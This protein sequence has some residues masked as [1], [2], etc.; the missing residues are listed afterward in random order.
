MYGLMTEDGSSVVCSR[1]GSKVFII[2]RWDR[3]SMPVTKSTQEEIERLQTLLSRISK[4]QLFIFE[5]TEDQI[6]K[7]M[8]RKLQG[9]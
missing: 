5:F 2:K 9:Y 1:T 4:R 3:A 7:I 8:I 6:E